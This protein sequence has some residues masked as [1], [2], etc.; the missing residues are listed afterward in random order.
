MSTAS[1]PS[2]ASSQ[3]FW[4]D[5]ARLAISVSLGFEGTG[6][7]TSGAGGPITEPIAP[8]YPDLPTNSFFTYGMLEG[9][10]RLLAFA[11]WRDSPAMHR[12][13]QASCFCARM[14]LRAGRCRPRDHTAREPAARTGERVGRIERSYTGQASLTAAFKA[15]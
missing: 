3:S 2:V 6:Q 5:G 7:P 1:S 8:G 9:V 15:A 10:P 12:A 13:I 4:P 14:Q 11:L